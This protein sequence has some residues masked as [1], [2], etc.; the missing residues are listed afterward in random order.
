MYFISRAT[1]HLLNK[2]PHYSCFPPTKISSPDSSE[3]PTEP[4]FGDVDCF[5]AEIAP[6]INL[7]YHIVALD[8][9]LIYLYP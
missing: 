2:R 8:A 1:K 3:N 5:I 6:T 4:T 9:K 7:T